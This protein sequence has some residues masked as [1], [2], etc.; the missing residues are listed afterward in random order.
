MEGVSNEITKKE[1]T[2]EERRELETKL[3]RELDDFIAGLR[4]RD[5]EVVPPDQLAEELTNHPFFLKKLPEDGSVPPLVDGLQQ[6][7]Y[8]E[9]ENTTEELALAHKDD[10]NQAFK[11][12][13]YRLAVMSYTEGIAK[14]ST[15]KHINATL[16]NNRA[17]AHFR[18]KNY[19][20]CYND[21]KKALEMDPQYTK[22]IVR[23]A[24]VC[25]ELELFDECIA[26]C[27]V[28]EGVTGKAKEFRE[29]TQKALKKKN[30]KSRNERKKI[31]QRKKVESAV[32][33]VENAIK[34]RGITM[35]NS[36]LANVENPLMGG[37]V[38]G[39][40]LEDGKL[41]WPV[42]L[43]Y[44]EYSMTEVIQNFHEDSTFEEQLSEV[45][46]D[47]PE[48]DVERKYNLNS[49]RVYY[50]DDSKPHE[51]KIKSTLKSVITRKTYIVEAATPAFI[52]FVKDSSAERRFL[53]KD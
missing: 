52:I 6:L 1:W 26:H 14:K 34:E 19:R 44:P 46:A 5:A 13:N 4:K 9:H 30:E 40:H 7:K 12:A 48:W 51:V 29:M 41:V 23:L 15:D 11:V 38:S 18:L 2:D 10:G 24:D 22:A 25:M 35:R 27:K 3:D 36:E 43:L 16:Y 8:S 37:P 39:V 32:S 47:R 50:E 21:C 42:V 53:D 31:F 20:S 49:I 28:L 33:S 17:A 45:F